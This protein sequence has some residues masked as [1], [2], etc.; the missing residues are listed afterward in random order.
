M[1]NK[2]RN[3]DLE[4]LINKCGGM[5]GVQ[6]LLTGTAEVVLRKHV[7]DLNA[8]AFVPD[9][10]KVEEHQ[11]TANSCGTLEWDANNV[12]FYLDDDQKN[13]QVIEGNKLRKRLARKPILNANVLDYLLQNPKLIPDSWKKDESGDTRYVFFWGTIYRN[14]KGDLRVRSLCWFGGRWRW[15]ASWLE[16]AWAS[17][18]PAA[19]HSN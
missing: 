1:D 12:E 14:Q 4:E 5:E 3:L 10:W 17:G 7:I 8:E 2:Y 11:I 13:G 6:R 16:S 15:H 19:L 18:D 9:G